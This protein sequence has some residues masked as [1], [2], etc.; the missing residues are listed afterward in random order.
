MDSTKETVVP[1]IFNGQLTPAFP[2]QIFQIIKIDSLGKVMTAI[3]PVIKVSPFIPQGAARYAVNVT[4]SPKEPRFYRI[5]LKE[6]VGGSKDP[7]VELINK[8]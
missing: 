5:S 7:T 1:V 2:D 8:S 3:V 4:F 6:Y